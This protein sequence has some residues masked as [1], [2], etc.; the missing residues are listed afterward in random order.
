MSCF[1]LICGIR[2]KIKRVKKPKG[3]LGNFVANNP[4]YYCQNCHQMQPTCVYRTVDWFTFFFIPICPV[5][6]GNQFLTCAVCKCPMRVDGRGQSCK[7]C[8]NWIEGS[9]RFCSSCGAQ[10]QF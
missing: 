3:P 2:S 9:D 8:R 1:I 6:F 7:Q 5:F 10:R 4:V